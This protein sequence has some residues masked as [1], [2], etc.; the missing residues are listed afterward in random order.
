MFHFIYF[1][2]PSVIVL[3]E[4]DIDNP[5]VHIGIEN[6]RTY[7]MGHLQNWLLYRGDTLKGIANLRDAQV[8]VL[9]YFKQRTEQKLY[10]PTPNKKWLSE[11][12]QIMGMTLKSNTLKDMPNIQK[13]FE[14]E[15]TNLNSVVDWNKSLDGFPQFSV[16]NIEKYANMVTAGVLSKSTIIKK[17]F[18]RGEQLLEE[19]YVDIGSI[20]TKQSDISFV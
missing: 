17:H 1:S 10:D 5:H 20:F 15:L 7:S 8:K 2:D 18:S 16:E 9:Q 19:Q 14:Y 12:V 11:K 13:D 3:T 4:H 6:I